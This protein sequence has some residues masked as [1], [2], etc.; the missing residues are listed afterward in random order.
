MSVVKLVDKSDDCRHIGVKDL[1]EDCIKGLDKYDPV[2]NKAV[3]IF[4]NTEDDG[5]LYDIFAAGMKNSE[6][7]ALLEIAKE[8]SKDHLV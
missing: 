7:V 5:Y 6:I 2:P 4:L 1:L 3:V 8:R